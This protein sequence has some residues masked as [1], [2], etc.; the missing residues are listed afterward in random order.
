[1]V[2][3][4]RRL[5]ALSDDP[6]SV[7][8]TIAST[9]SGTLASVAPQENS[10]EASNPLSAKYFFVI[11]TTSVAILFPFKT[12]IVLIF[13]DSDTAKTHLTGLI[14]VLRRLTYQL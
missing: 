7:R 5:F 9:S 8:S 11:L 6:V 13:E 10:T 2:S 12:S 3:R 4:T 1:M 14:L